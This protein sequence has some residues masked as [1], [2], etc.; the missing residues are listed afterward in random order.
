MET[1]DL[2]DGPCFKNLQDRKIH[3]VWTANT[4]FFFNLDHSLVIH[5]DSGSQCSKRIWVA[6]SGQ[7][8]CPLIGMNRIIS[9]F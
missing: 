8:K 7:K 6:F 4:F 3:G 2:I 1:E 5:L 9:S